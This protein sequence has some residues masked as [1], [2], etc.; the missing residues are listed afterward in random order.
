VS[1]ANWEVNGVMAHP[2]FTS[3]SL[4][5]KPKPEQIEYAANLSTVRL[6]YRKTIILIN[7][8]VERQIIL[9]LGAVKIGVYLYV[10][11]SKCCIRRIK[12]NE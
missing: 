6:A 7:R 12:N 1:L 8:W 11:G 4:L 9:H 3:F 2:L 10:N 5:F